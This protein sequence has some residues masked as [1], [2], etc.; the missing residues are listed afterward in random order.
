MHLAKLLVREGLVSVERIRE[1][2][3]HGRESGCEMGEALADLGYVSES[4]LVELLAKEYGVPAM[5]I[6][7][8]EP[9]EGV[10]GL[11]PVET[12]LEKFLVP[13]TVDG[14][15]LIIAMSDPS[16]ILLLD[17]LGFITGK[18][19]KPVVAPYRSIRDKLSKYYREKDVA[20][21]APGGE[22]SE[23][24]GLQ[25]RPSA[26]F[27]SQNKETRPVDDIIKELELYKNDRFPGSE[28]SAADEK[29]LNG[30][31]DSV[32]G[33]DALLNAEAMSRVDEVVNEPFEK[34][35]FGDHP[36]PDDLPRPASADQTD[37][38]VGFPDK[39]AFGDEPAGDAPAAGGLAAGVD[40]TRSSD[41]ASG[42]AA[43]AS[44][45]GSAGAG[46]P[47]NGPHSTLSGKNRQG[48][49]GSVLIVEVSPT[50][51]KIMRIALERAGYL[52]YAAGDGIQALASINEIIPDLIF[53][54]IELPHM[55]GYQFCKVIKS[56]GLTKEVPVVMLSGKIGV[57]DKMK[58]K[59][60]GAD[61]FIAKPFGPG[62]LVQA[63]E[64]YMRSSAQEATI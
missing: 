22:L 47:P 2:I 32:R 60:S 12:A 4:R 3:E 10:L 55:D 35:G 6:D 48:D 50:V 31:A 46:A 57:L 58:V 52:V 25:D 44:D 42:D 7:G 5:D 8:C 20:G 34:S 33:N 18:N 13:I 61:D 17:D 49:R 24:S 11:V 19:I 45:E 14:S 16:D 63:A 41:T 1:A 23:E 51:R 37:G 27:S 36:G 39:Y 21:S 9:D 64:K 53:V 28:I 40:E 59:M 43:S 15:D 29:G 62:A 26:S 54:G 56:H 30:E 38:H